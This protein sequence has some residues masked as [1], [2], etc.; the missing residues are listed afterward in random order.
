[1][2]KKT[3]EASDDQTIEQFPSEVFHY[4]ELFDVSQENSL[5]NKPSIRK[6]M[7]NLQFIVKMMKIK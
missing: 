4:E 1:V 7:T 2:T 3:V 6:K 5:K